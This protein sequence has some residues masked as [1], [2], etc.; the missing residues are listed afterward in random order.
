MG[1]HVSFVALG[2]AHVYRET[3]YEPAIKLAEKLIRY[4]LEEI[5]YI[6]ADGRFGSDR[7]GASQQAHFHM[8]TYA[9]LAILEYERVTGD[10]AWLEQVQRGFEYGIAHGDRLLGYFPEL[11]RKRRADLRAGGSGRHDR[12]PETVRRLD[13]RLLGRRRPLGAQHVRRGAAAAHRLDRAGRGRCPPSEIDE[14]CQTSE[15]VAER[16]L[17]AFASWPKANDWFDA[18]HFYGRGIMHC[19]TGNGTRAIYYIWESSPTTTACAS[20]CSSTGPRPGPTSTA[21]S[22]TGARSTSRSNSRLTWLCASPEW[23]APAQV[24]V[25]VGGADRPLRWDG[26]YAGV[27]RVKPGDAVTM[28][29]PMVDRTDTVSIEN[30]DIPAD[31][32][33]QRGGGDRPAGPLL[34]SLPARSLPPEQHALARDRTIRL[35]GAALLVKPAARARVNTRPPTILAQHSHAAQGGMD[36]APRSRIDRVDRPAAARSRPQHRRAGAELRR[37]RRRRHL[38]QEPLRPR[39]CC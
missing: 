26:R 20:T 10:T 5:R 7:P 28:T 36:H 17:G 22:P 14:S 31:A 12:G 16:N 13:R 33:R 37:D 15:Q 27:G 23:V 38:L 29:F 21:I 3:G 39:P 30:G 32:Q 35:P 6:E 18:D 34:P 1:A 24:R 2:M 8:H 4:T 11:L 25:T 9:L 19:C